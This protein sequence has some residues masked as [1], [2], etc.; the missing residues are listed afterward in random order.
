M[1]YILDLY[2]SPQFNFFCHFKSIAGHQLAE[3]KTESYRIEWRR[4]YLH[5]HS[6][7][8]SNQISD[9]LFFL[10]PEYLFIHELELGVIL[11]ALSNKELSMNKK[12]QNK[13]RNGRLVENFVYFL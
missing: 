6:N 7:P 11:I 4:L 13:N 1:F 12:E 2:S 5:L 8:I 9:T 10:A 3:K